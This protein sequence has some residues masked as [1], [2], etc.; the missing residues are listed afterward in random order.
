ML[1]ILFDTLVYDA[2]GN[3]FGHSANVMDIWYIIPNLGVSENTNF[4]SWYRQISRGAE[5]IIKTF[6]KALDKIES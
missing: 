5:N 2:G 4:T 1:D 6:Y 3:Y